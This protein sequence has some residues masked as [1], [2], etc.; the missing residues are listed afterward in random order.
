LPPTNKEGSLDM[1][2]NKK[3]VEH[4]SNSSQNRG[5]TIQLRDHDYM[6]NEHHDGENMG[7]NQSIVTQNHFLSLDQDHLNNDHV[8]KS[9]EVENKVNNQ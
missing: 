6:G 2:H 5:R 7:C 4:Q 9:R 3:N 1:F 8:H